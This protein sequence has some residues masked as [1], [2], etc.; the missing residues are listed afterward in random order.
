MT[1]TVNE[2]LEQL[3]VMSDTSTA[4]NDEVD[5]HWMEDEEL[6]NFALDYERVKVLD[7]DTKESLIYILGR[8]LELYT[9]ED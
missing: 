2:L 8:R 7:N 1:R 9:D 5:F 4:H 6:I 3:A